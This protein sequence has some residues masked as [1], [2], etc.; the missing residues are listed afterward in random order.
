MEQTNIPEDMITDNPATIED[1]SRENKKLKRRLRDME[2][3]VRRNQAMMA[4]RTTINSI[5]ESEQQKTDRYMNLMLENSADII[6]LL[7]NTCRFSYY[8]NTFLKTIGSLRSDNISGRHLTEV[9]TQPALKE[10]VDVVQANIDI[11]TKRRSTVV[12]N[13]SLDF[14][15]R[16]NPREYDV[17]ITPMTDSK[18]KP[19]AFMLLLHDI[20]D[21]LHSKRQAESANIAKSRFLATMS[22][23]MRTPMNAVLGMTVIGKAAGDKERMMYCFAKIED[24]SRH[25][26]GV[27]NDILDM[28]KIEADKFEL[29]PADFNFEKMLQRVVNVVNYRVDE[30]KQKFTVHIDEAIPD[31]LIGD[32]QRLAQVITNLLGNAVKFTPDGGAIELDARLINEEND[33]YTIQITVTDTGIGIS[34]EQKDSLFLSFQQAESDTSR[35]F[36]G[37]GLGISISKSIAEMMGGSIRVESELG[38]GSAFSFTVRL[39]RGA[40]DLTGQSALDVNGCLGA[41]YGQPSETPPDE[42][43]DFTGHCILLAEDIEINR[44]IVLSLLE[45]TGLRTCCAN[46]GAEAVRMFSE[47]PCKYDMIFM[48]V[49]MP[50]TDGYEATRRIRALDIRRAKTIPIIAMTANVFREDVEK[51]IEAGMNGH[52]GKP[53]DQNEVFRQLRLCL[54]PV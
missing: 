24:A 7:D 36:G 54:K 9:F 21:I 3:T 50:V 5:L 13:S 17:Q 15:G 40:R 11:A 19:E 25:L 53:L 48:D 23:E 35:K 39:K 49:Q 2:F 45:P 32:D 4:A 37:T 34:P 43:D 44:E 18:G 27:I 26:L 20:T 10:W 1:L 38:K 12:I 52:I 14:S 16:G 8:T 30:K 22:H 33:L 29:S 47:E 46:D 6:L 28:S 51:C 41:N 42:P 31:N